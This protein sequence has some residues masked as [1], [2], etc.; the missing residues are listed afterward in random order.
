MALERAGTGKVGGDALEAWGPTLAPSEA[1]GLQ[2][3]RIKGE[4]RRLDKQA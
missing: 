4:A 2:I 3:A 1:A